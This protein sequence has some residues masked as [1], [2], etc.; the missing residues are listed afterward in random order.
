MCI[1]TGVKVNIHLLSMEGFSI[2]FCPF[3]FCWNARTK[4]LINIYISHYCGVWTQEKEAT[5]LMRLSPYFCFCVNFP[6]FYP[7]YRHHLLLATLLLT[8][9]I[10][11]PRVTLKLSNFQDLQKERFG[12]KCA[13]NV[14]NMLYFLQ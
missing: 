13:S 10:F 3:L 7:L 5:C 2:F 1:T 12:G 11:F 6:W 14:G 4:W 8:F 9:S